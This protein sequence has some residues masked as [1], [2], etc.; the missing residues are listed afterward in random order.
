MFVHLGIHSVEY[1]A[2][3]REVG[4]FEYH[5]GGRQLTQLVFCPCTLH[6]VVEGGSCLQ[7]L[8]ADQESES[9]IP[10]KPGSPVNR[11]TTASDTMEQSISTSYIFE[12]MRRCEVSRTPVTVRSVLLF[13]SKVLKEN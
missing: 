12:K 2:Y 13:G 11:A 5:K 1:D 4:P 8:V 3:K 10:G 6:L 7:Y 9:A